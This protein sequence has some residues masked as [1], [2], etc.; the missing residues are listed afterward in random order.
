[1][2]QWDFIWKIEKVLSN[3]HWNL[4]QFILEIILFCLSWDSFRASLVPVISFG[5]NELYQRRSVFE[6]I[7]DVIPWGRTILGVLP[8]RRSVF[9]LD[10]DLTKWLNNYLKKIKKN[11]DWNISI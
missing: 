5:E 7:S 3:W 8:L 10:T 1:M 11:I 2:I 9:T 6:L 4:G